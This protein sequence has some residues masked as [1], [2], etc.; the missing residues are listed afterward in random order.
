MDLEGVVC[1]G[2][3]LNCLY[4]GS[5]LSLPLASHLALSGFMSILD[6]TQ[7]PPRCALASFRQ[8]GF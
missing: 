6:L 4:G 7:G 8:D 2:C 3:D 5:F 1:F